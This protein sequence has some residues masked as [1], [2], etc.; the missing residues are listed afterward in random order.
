M[1]LNEIFTKLI[2][3][4]VL[5]KY[6]TFLFFTERDIVWTIQKLLINHCDLKNIYSIYN[7]YGILP[8]NNINAKRKL[9]SDLVI[10]NNETKKV[11]LVIEF[12]YEPSHKR[13]DIMKNKFPVINFNGVLKDI[14]K[15]ET[16]KQKFLSN[17]VI[18]ILFDENLSFKSLFE[19]NKLYP[20]IISNQYVDIYIIKK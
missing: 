4:E 1:N 17:S 11:E 7:D 20:E 6:H 13:T 18:S 9:S 16:I 12:K 5:K 2:E 8:S 19:K 10:V 14:K 3:N 15:I